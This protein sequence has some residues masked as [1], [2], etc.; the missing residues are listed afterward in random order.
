[1]RGMQVL[2]MTWKDA[3]PKQPEIVSKM[4]TNKKKVIVEKKKEKNRSKTNKKKCRTLYYGQTHCVTQGQVGP[5]Q[6]DSDT[7]L[8]SQ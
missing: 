4:F 7:T 3:L 8:R 5:T 6:K 1:M 2:G